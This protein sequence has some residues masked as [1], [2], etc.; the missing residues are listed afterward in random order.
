L[1][2]AVVTRLSKIYSAFVLVSMLMALLMTSV[3][4]QAAEKPTRKVA[5]SK[6]ARAKAVRK[7]AQRAEEPVRASYANQAGLH[8]A[9][10]PLAL[11]SAVALVMDQDTDEVLFS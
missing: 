8:D 4:V 10:D 1:G 7:V 2:F 3:A 6:H 5:S 9:G 11:K